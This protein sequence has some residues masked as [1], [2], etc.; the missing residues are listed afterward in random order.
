VREAR[1]AE[2]RDLVEDL[3]REVEAALEVGRHD[4]R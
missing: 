4:D 3:A 1:C 2:Y